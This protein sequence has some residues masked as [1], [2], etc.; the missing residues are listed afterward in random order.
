[1]TMTQMFQEAC[2]PLFERCPTSHL[3]AILLLL[4]LMTVHGVNNAFAYW[5]FSFLGIGL[6]PKGNNLPKSM[7]HVKRVIQQ[8]G[9][10]YKSIHA[11]YNGCVLFRGD[12]NDVTSCSK[13]KKSH[14]IDVSDCVPCKMFQHFTLIPCLKQMY[15]CFSL[16]E[17]MSWHDA[18]KNDDGMVRL[19]FDSKAWKHVDNIW[20][21]FATNPWNIR[22]GLALDGVNP[23]V[24]LSTSHSTW[25]ILFLNYNLPPQLIIKWLFVILT[26]LI[27]R[28]KS[29]NNDNI[30]VYLQ[31]LVEG[32]KALWV[33]ILTYDVTRNK[34]FLRFFNVSHLIVEHP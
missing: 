20:L 21:R 16:M 14:F 27:I 23:Y 9:L 32:L 11:C 15:Q 25:Q 5:F 4:N 31:P 17:L 12:L 22:L 7:Y 19:V 3:I 8:L 10:G 2:T 6:F 33:R 1:M 18:N 29:V 30:D 24:D 26:L 28:K 34:G 13:C